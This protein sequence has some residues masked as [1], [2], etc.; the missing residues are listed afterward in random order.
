MKQ[1]TQFPVFEP[2]PRYLALA[3]AAT[4]GT[5]LSAASA[6]AAGSLVSDVASGALGPSGAA[7]ALL[8]YLALSLAAQL[9]TFW[10]TGWLPERENLR[11]EVD[12]SE[13]AI[14][15]VLSMPQRAFARHDQGHYL[16]LV[17]LAA[18]AHGAIAVV[19][20]AYVPGAVLSLAVLLSAA[21]LVG[22]PLAAVLALCVVAYVALV[23]VPSRAANR[24]QTRM[25]PA[26][27]AWA[28]VA[29]RVVEERRAAVAAG[30]EGFYASRYRERTDA[31]R[32]SR[33]G[34][35]LA[36]TLSNELPGASGLLVQTLAV[37]ACA[38]AV[39]GA[40]AGTLVIAWQLAG[41]LALPTSFLCEGWSVYAANR[42]NVDLLRALE[43][44]AA[45]PS[46]FERLRGTSCRPSPAPASPATATDPAT[47]PATEGACHA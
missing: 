16:N 1:R 17:N 42:V 11:R 2:R 38:L 37:A 33:R 21:W 19:M 10:L 43:R 6:L 35:V 30:A 41:L 5:A 36:S 40:D 46:G 9:A 31:Y 3:L 13:R 32:R 45:A 20:S 24:L 18:F 25:L 28:D 44:E 7:T 26:R 39:G 4:V 47:E 34:Y 14:D 23:L 15:L 8:G 12:S 29:R 22:P 27:N